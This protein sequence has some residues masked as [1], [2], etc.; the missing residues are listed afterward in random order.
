VESILPALAYGPVCTSIVGLRNSVSAEAGGAAGE[1]METL[2]WQSTA[3]RPARCRVFDA[4]FPVLVRT[5]RIS[6]PHV[7]PCKPSVPSRRKFRFRHSAAA[8]SHAARPELAFLL[9][10]LWRSARARNAPSHRSRRSR[11]CPCCV[12]PSEPSPKSRRAG[13][14]GPRERSEPNPRPPALAP[15][16]KRALTPPFGLQIALEVCQRWRSNMLVAAGLAVLVVV[17]LLLSMMQTPPEIG[18]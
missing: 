14:L 4:E 13:P 5:A 15:R 1:S 12:E 8:N 17:C 11:R 18:R 3:D 16:A 6:S 10:T 7:A 2:R 9:K